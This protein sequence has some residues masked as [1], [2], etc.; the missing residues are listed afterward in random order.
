MK[1]LPHGAPARGVVGVVVSAAA[2]VE[3]LSC[4]CVAAVPMVL[5]KFFRRC[6]SS[7]FHWGIGSTPPVGFAAVGD[8]L[9]VADSA[10]MRK[11]ITKFIYFIFLVSHSQHTEFALLRICIILLSH[12]IAVVVVILN[13]RTVHR[14]TTVALWLCEFRYC[15]YFHSFVIVLC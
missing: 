8:A 9:V 7:F 6:S 15:G 4:T 1:G 5:A 2:T 13:H 12:Y 11:P 10:I 3:A 14:H